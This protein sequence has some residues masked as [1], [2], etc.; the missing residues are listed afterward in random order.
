[1]SLVRCNGQQ[2]C[3]QTGIWGSRVTA[4][5][6]MATLY[7]RWDRQAFVERGQAFPRAEDQFIDVAMSDLQWTYLGSPNA[8]TGMPGIYTIGL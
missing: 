4:E 3:P 1:V 8:E 7:N 2:R 5:H 6:P